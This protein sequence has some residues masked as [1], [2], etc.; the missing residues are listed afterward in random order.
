MPSPG[1][2]VIFQ[3]GPVSRDSVMAIGVIGS[4]ASSTQGLQAH[5]RVI[6]DRLALLNPDRPE[7]A[8]ACTA[9]R[10]VAGYAGWPA[11]ALETEIKDG[12]WHLSALE[13]S[14]AI[15]MDPVLMWDKATTGVSRD[16]RSTGKVEPDH[17]GFQHYVESSLQQEAVRRRRPVTALCGW[18][19]IP[20]RSAATGDDLGDLPVCP[21]C[22]DIHDSMPAESPVST[23]RF[24]RWHARRTTRLSHERYADD[25]I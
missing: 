16:S 20:R 6:R 13:P 1:S 24:G 9:V 14:E 22:K 8:A 5:I 4:A 19:W 21:R 11:N 7:D 23:R 25:R 18:T 2:R 17:G 15:A 12:I 10:I 3:G